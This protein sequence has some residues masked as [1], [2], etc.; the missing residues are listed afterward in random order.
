MT[1]RLA[2]NAPRKAGWPLCEHDRS[3]YSSLMVGANAKTRLL[4]A[5]LD[6]LSREGMGGLTLGRVADAAALS[7]SGLFAH[8][9]SK[10][11]LSIALL[12]AGA[13]LARRHVVVPAMQAPSGLARLRALID[14]WLGWSGRAGLSGGCPI[15]AALFELD[16]RP[17]P[18]RDHVAML[19]L[20]WRA[21]LRGLVSEAVGQGELRADLDVEQVVWELCGIYLSHHSASRFLHDPLSDERAKRAVEALIERAGRSF[22]A[23]GSSC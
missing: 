5:G 3:C 7:K 8:V 17:G 15:A 6:L 18:V 10:E 11:Q 16:D 13:D 12:D 14:R 1:R 19:E 2:E 20:R 21:L 23:V 9:R 22:G 4:E